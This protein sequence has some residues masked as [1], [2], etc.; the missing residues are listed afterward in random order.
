MN[1]I[2]II[3]EALLASVHPKTRVV[4]AGKVIRLWPSEFKKEE[5]KAGIKPYEAARVENPTY[6]DAHEAAMRVP[7]GGSSCASCEYLGKD[8]KS[9]TNKYFIKWHGSSELPYPADEFC[10]DWYEPKV[11]LE[12]VGTSEGVKKE[13]DT[14]GRKA[15]ISGTGWVLPNGHFVEAKDLGRR[16]EEHSKAAVR[17]GLATVKSWN[18]PNQQAMQRGAVRVRNLTSGT[19]TL[20]AWTKDKALSVMDRLDPVVQHVAIEWWNPHHGYIS[21]A[22]KEMNAVGTSAGVKKE[23]D[24]RGRGKKK[25]DDYQGDGHGTKITD[26]NEL[27]EGWLAKDGMFYQNFDNIHSRTAMLHKLAPP[28]TPQHPWATGEA[29][30]RGHVRVSPGSWTVILEGKAGDS[31]V[32]ERMRDALLLAKADHPIA[33]EFV[34]PRKPGESYSGEAFMSKDFKNPGEADEYLAKGASA[35]ID[36]DAA[37]VELSSSGTLDGVM[38]RGVH[39]I[40]FTSVEEE[41][42]TAFMS[43]IPPELVVGV[44]RV[45]SDPKLGAIHGRYDADSKTIFFNAKTFRSQTILGR[46][47]IKIHHAQL[48]MVHEFGHAL[49]NSLPDEKR[50]EWMALSDWMEGSKAGQARPYVE[51]RPGWPHKTSKWTHAKDAK[52]TRHYAEKNP[53]EDAADTFAFVLLGHGMQAGKIKC[54]WMG[55]LL[56][57]M[58][59]HYP[60]ASI[61]SP[62]KL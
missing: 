11:A 39:I 26:M 8:G 35:E 56:M 30:A 42:V 37:V 14:R 52:F 20:E 10:S 48:T 33:L 47:P 18:D 13:W 49:Y 32:L 36:L 12:A 16:M 53:D 41:Q 43:R 46:G 24:T 57:G 40:G 29:I 17:L 38:F 6:P 5:R 23:W 59:N 44:K 3:V 34:K 22:M 51:K 54:A 4:E 61:Q 27:K 19:V 7:K 28:E 58:I 9:C 2:D 60:Q 50:K 1:E 62:E 21:D 55:K 15:I 25:E 45:V 31:G